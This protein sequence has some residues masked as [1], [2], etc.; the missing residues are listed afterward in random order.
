MREG[1]G[2]GDGLGSSLGSSLGL[3]ARDSR[4]RCGKGVSRL[5]VG[6]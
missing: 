3:G 2:Y 6:S 1:S 4:V 5:R